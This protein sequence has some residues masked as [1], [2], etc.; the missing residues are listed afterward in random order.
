MAIFAWNE[1]GKFCLVFAPGIDYG[2]KRA[3]APQIFLSYQSQQS[4]GN[5]SFEITPFSRNGNRQQN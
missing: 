2:E 4:S 1:F 3:Q 5:I